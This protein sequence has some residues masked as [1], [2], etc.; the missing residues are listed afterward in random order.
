MCGGVVVIKQ[1]LPCLSPL[2]LNEKDIQMRR[3]FSH[4]CKRHFFN[5]AKPISEILAEFGERFSIS[6]E[7]PVYKEQNIYVHFYTLW[8]ECTHFYVGIYV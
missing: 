8:L 6:K 3:T 2:S 4:F 7:G 1:G 5:F